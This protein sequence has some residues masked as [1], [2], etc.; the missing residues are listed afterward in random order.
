MDDIKKIASQFR[1]KF[2]TDN[3]FANLRNR[4]FQIPNVNVED[5]INYKYAVGQLRYNKN[6]D[7][8]IIYWNDIK[9]HTMA[10]SLGRDI[11]L[12]DNTSFSIFLA[13]IKHLQSLFYSQV[14][15]EESFKL[16]RLP[17]YDEDETKHCSLLFNNV[18]MCASSRREI[19]YGFGRMVLPLINF[20]FTMKPQIDVQILNA[21]YRNLNNSFENAET[22]AQ[23]NDAANTAPNDNPTQMLVDE[24]K[25]ET[26]KPFILEPMPEHE[27]V[28]D[29]INEYLNTPKIL[30]KNPY[31][32]DATPIITNKTP[33]QIEETPV[34][35]RQRFSSED[36]DGDDADDSASEQMLPITPIR[37]QRPVPTTSLGTKRK[38]EPAKTTTSTKPKIYDFEK[39]QITEDED[40]N[41]S[42]M[43]DDEESYFERILANDEELEE[44]AKKIKATT[45]MPT[46][47][48]ISSSF[49]NRELSSLTVTLTPKNMITKIEKFYRNYIFNTRDAEVGLVQLEQLEDDFV[50]FSKQMEFDPQLVERKQTTIFHV[51][52]KSNY[53]NTLNSANNNVEAIIS[54]FAYVK[55]HFLKKYELL[56]K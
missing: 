49:L 51:E 46:R 47:S 4:E 29:D 48:V 21:F 1:F 30:N 52:S 32:V 8:V 14:I 9:D 25:V 41:S 28:P 42:I 11:L 31:N 7:S 22:A 10:K 19:K 12:H 44:P 53:E 40:T 54:F 24:T 33:I 16:F 17:E 35:R 38:R 13:L 27:G 3:E 56:N 34:R 45:S 37:L 2:Y 20:T 43:D 26:H 55:Y 36:D 15:F 6:E 50:L 39:T 23:I 5:Q 18:A